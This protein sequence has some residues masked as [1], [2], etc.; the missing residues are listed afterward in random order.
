M[1][2]VLLALCLCLGFFATAQTVTIPDPNFKAAL[3]NHDPVIDTNGDGEIQVSEAEAVTGEINVD[4]TNT[5]DLTGIEAFVNITRLSCNEADITTI[6][7]TQNVNLLYLDCFNTDIS[8]IDLSQNILL[9]EVILGGGDELLSEVDVTNNINLKNLYCW[10]L[11]NLTSIDVSNNTLLEVLWVSDNDLDLLD[12]SNNTA[13]RTLN[14][15]RNNLTTIDISNLS[16][17]ENFS[18]GYNQIEILDVSQNLNLTSLI[19]YVNSLSELDISQNVNLL[20][21]DCRN[22]ELQVLD[23]SQNIEMKSLR[24]STNELQSLD[25]SENLLLE[26]LT[27]SYNNLTSLDLSGNENICDLSVSNNPNL[28]YINFKNGNNTI[29]VPGSICSG[30][31]PS[32]FDASDNPNLQYIC[33]DDLDYGVE[34]FLN[35]PPGVI[36]TEDCGITTGDTNIIQGS[37]SFDEN[38]DGC[39]RFDIKIG[40][41]FVSTTDGINDIGSASLESG[42]Y[43]LKVSENTYTT[44]VVG[45]S[46]YFT[47]TPSETVDTFTGFN[48]SEIADFCIAPAFT[49]NDLAISI[50]PTDVARPGFEANYTLTYENVGTTTLS[51]AITLEFDESR[52]SFV[53]A[54]PSETSQVNNTI[55]WSYNSLQPFMSKSISVDFSVLPP[56]TNESGDVLTFTATANPI[57]TDETPDDNVFEL[58]QE[59]VNSYDPNDKQVTQGSQ[60]LIDKA[61]E[62][63]HYVIRFQNLGTASAI[64]V[65]VQD[66]LDELLDWTTLK[67]LDSSHEMNVEMVDGKI[68]FIF[69]D[70]NLPTEDTNPEASQGYVAYKIKPQL[71]IA[72]GDVIE[73]TASI[74]FDFNPAIITNTVSTTYVEELGIGEF[75]ESNIVL[76]PNPTENNFTIE[77]VSRIKKIEVLN[78]LGQTIITKSGASNK[79]E[80]SISGLQTGNYFVKVTS[81]EGSETIRLLKR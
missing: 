52:I 27:C 3:L 76:Y 49:A 78:V 31:G 17:L 77:A 38:M 2:H 16:E 25:L 58:N 56:P 36:F 33:I 9:E 11:P 40:N 80:I 48:Q 22:N 34:T 10:A 15:N 66:D 54:S 12:V 70:I 1:K 59:V 8:T 19:C 65:R 14:C 35:V 20:N 41:I 51:G 39:D 4:G 37:L 67:I 81:E 55:T 44:S 62:Y 63:L 29:L 64:N 6:D 57:S 53:S 42:F 24:C 28:E 50:I 7:I 74:Y 23:V 69:N 45:L 73:N 79:E 46:S 75:E 13:L 47:V 68:D 61:D 32:D 26:R 30:S 5:T 71:G 43:T 18:C 60:V 21:L 72:I